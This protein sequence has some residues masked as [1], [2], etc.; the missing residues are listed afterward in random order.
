[1]LAAE[2]APHDVG[3]VGGLAADQFLGDRRRE[4]ERHRVDGE[5]R[6]FVVVQGEHGAHRNIVVLNAAAGLVVAGAAAD[7]EA[8]LAA[9]QVAI[10]SGAAAATLDKVIEASQAAAAAAG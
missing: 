3:V 7:L 2:H 4:P 8:G 1:V 6:D 10:D 9:A 5:R